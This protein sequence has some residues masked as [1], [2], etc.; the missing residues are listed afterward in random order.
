MNYRE[1]LS[2]PLSKNFLDQLVQ[3]IFDQPED[4]EIVYLLIFDTHTSIAWRAAWACEK[5]SEVHSDWFSEKQVLEI[6]DF[7][8]N[9]SHGGLHRGCLSILC[10]LRLPNSI[11]V[12]FINGC[13]NWMISPKCPIAVQA[14]SMK[15]LFAICQKE[16]DLKFEL[17]A[18]LENVDAECYSAGFN[19]TRK[20]ILKK[21]NI[22]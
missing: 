9:V 12:S 11:P 13:F 1:Q 4:L 15:L 6:M 2:R 8:I 14:L 7:S 17:K 19:S 3:S 18:Y 16:P 5:V 21:L 20:N 22:S 10:N